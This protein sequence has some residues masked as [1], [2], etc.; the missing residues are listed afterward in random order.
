[1]YIEIEIDEDLLRKIELWERR[2]PKA[3]ERVMKDMSFMFEAQAKKT[4]GSKGRPKVRSGALRAS[5]RG[6]AGKTSGKQYAG[7]GSNLVYARIQEKGGRIVAKRAD[8]LTFKTGAG[9]R[10]WAKKKAITIPARPYLEP[11]MREVL[12]KSE[13]IIAKRIIEELER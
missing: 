12:K 13:K 11:A 3:L 2:L 5:I 8:Y 7:V 1:M 6:T 9:K 4:F 10:D